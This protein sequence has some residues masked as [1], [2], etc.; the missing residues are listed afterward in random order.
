MPARASSIQRAGAM[1]GS[2]PKASA[3]ALMRAQW[4][5]RSGVTPS[6]ARAPSNTEEAI[7]APCVR[8][9]MSGTLPSC[10]ASSKKV[11]VDEWLTG[12]CMGRAPPG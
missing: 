5:A 4:R 11:Q 10:Q 8:T 9:P 2:S 7:Q 1:A 12:E 6:K 3:E